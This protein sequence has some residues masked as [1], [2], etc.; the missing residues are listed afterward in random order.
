M[1]LTKKECEIAVLVCSGYSNRRIA[2]F[3]D[4]KEITI[5]GRIKNI[6]RKMKVK[7]RTQLMLRMMT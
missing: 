7:N 3:L 2:I 5:K 4:V 1:I 6:L